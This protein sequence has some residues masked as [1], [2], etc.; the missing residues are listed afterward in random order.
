LYFTDRTILVADSEKWDEQ[1]GED[2][3]QLERV[4][5]GEIQKRPFWAAER[6][7]KLRQK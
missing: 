6:K 1:L 5:E 7:E 3:C 4:S 2:L